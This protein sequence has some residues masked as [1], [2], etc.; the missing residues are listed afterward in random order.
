[1]SR[2]RKTWL[3]AFLIIGFLLSPALIFAQLSPGQYSE[4]SSL[5]SWNNFGA[6]AAASIGAGL[7][8]IVLSGGGQSLL[9]NPAFLASL[10]RPAIDLSFSFQQSQVYQYWMVNTGVLST[11]G[12]LGCQALGLSFAGLSGKIKDWSIALAVSQTENYSRPKIEYSYTSDGILYEQMMLSQTGRQT[13]CALGLARALTPRLSLGLSLAFIN[14]HLKR[15]FEDNYPAEGIKITDVR[16]QKISGVYLIFGAGYQLNKK[17]AV[18]FS[19]TP[20]YSRNFRGTSLAGFYSSENQIEI[21]GAGHDRVRMPLVAGV[22]LLYQ[23]NRSVG[24][25]LEAIY[26]DWK[27][28]SFKYFGEP[29]ERNFKSIF[30]LSFGFDYK[31]TFKFLG[32]KWEAPYYA[33]LILDPQPMT[34]VRSNYYYITFGSGMGNADFLLTFSTAIG[35]EKGSGH[36]LTNQK[37]CLSLQLRPSLIDKFRSQKKRK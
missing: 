7:R 22:G 8:Q 23:A 3:S 19:L 28:Y 13:V 29:L 14:G 17:L 16:E 5:G 12:N 31:S 36:H 25:S 26:F 32:K 34:D 18:G 2:Q 27:N 20:P 1:M 37:V 10:P 30:R 9:S 15:T 6:D 33:G 11:D 24:F 35:L 4:E 21:Q